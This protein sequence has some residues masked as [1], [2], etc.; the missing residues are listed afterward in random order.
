VKIIIPTHLSD[1]EL[2]AGLTRLAHS[3]REAT[4]TLIAHLAEFDYRSVFDP[5]QPP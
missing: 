3:T 2:T 4:V 5:G 1:A